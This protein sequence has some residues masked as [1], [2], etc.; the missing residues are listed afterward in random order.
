M[1][2]VI[3][4]VRSRFGRD[5]AWFTTLS[6]VERAIALVQ[7]VIISRVLGMVDYGVYGLL[8][9]TIGLVASVAGLQMGLAATV[10]VSRYRLTQKPKAAAVISIVH[11]FGWTTAVLAVGTTVPFSEDLSR[12]LLGSRDHHHALALGS[13][14]VG[15]SILS[16]VQDG[17]A[18]GFEIFEAIARIKIAISSIALVLIYP[19]AARFGLTGVLAVLITSLTLKMVIL[20]RSVS[21]SRTD[22]GIPSRGSGMSFGTLVSSFALP[23][24]AVSLMV[25]FVMWLGMLWLSRQPQGFESVAIVNTGLQWRSPIQLLTASVGGVA[26]PRFS[27]FDAAGDSV[28]AGR[29]RK[30][31]TLVSFGVAILV[32]GGLAAGSKA[33]LWMYGPDFTRGHVAFS[34]I[35]LST[36]PSVVAN[37]Y[38]QELVGS[39]RMWRQ[40]LLHIPLVVTAGLGFLLLVPTLGAL[41][42]AYTQLGSAVVLWGSVV[43]ASADDK[44]AR[45]FVDSGA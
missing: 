25:G 14:L 17:I 7:T 38:L 8:F 1:A 33:I 39:A 4:A 41:G 31:L 13:V 35:V 27:R 34:L 16:G 37:V 2:R 20:R 44:R 30:A 19:A 15:A 6:A 32:G 42:Y 11:R 10:F 45:T 40:L 43:V 5:A 29:F 21:Q 28:R 22:A 23:S 24:M 18:Q 26:V 9:G 36:I 12:L 3:A